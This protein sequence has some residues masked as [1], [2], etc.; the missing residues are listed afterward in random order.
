MPTDLSGPAWLRCLGDITAE[1]QGDIEEMDDETLM[2]ESER[3]EVTCP[4]TKPMYNDRDWRNY[5]RLIRQ[6]MHARG[7]S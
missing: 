1:R 3:V 6:E 2:D 4:P 7:L 5:R